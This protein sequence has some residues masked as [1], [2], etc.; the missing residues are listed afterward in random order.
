[1]VFR[2][3]SALLLVMSLLVVA[4]VAFT[5]PP[6]STRI[7]VQTA[8]GL[9]VVGALVALIDT[10]GKV[11]VE[12]LSNEDGARSLSVPA[13]TYRVQVRRIG[14]QPFIS[15]PLVL[16]R[17]E[18]VLLVITDQP[19]VLSTVTV[20]PGSRCRS[21]EQD[22][23]A[24]T[25]VWGEIAKA[26]RASQLTSEDVWG[27][28]LVR[29][30]TRETSRGGTIIRSD[31]TLRRAIGARPFGAVD[32]RIL[33]TTGYVHGNSTQGWEFFGPDE[34]VLLSDQ[35]AV[36]HCFKVVRDRKRFGQVG[37]SFEPVLG[38]KQ[39]DIAGVIWVSE[40]TAELQEMTFRYVNAGV[41][42]G[43]DAGGRTHFLKMPSGAWI[44]DEWSLRFPKLEGRPTG[45][46]FV[47]VGHFE[48]GGGIVRESL[49]VRRRI[50]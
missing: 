18:G 21:F 31:S 44:V 23:T 5:Q 42:S 24:L 1:M 48:T 35:F 30:Y 20:S 36:T 46:T 16:P 25:T 6:A 47:E 19:I 9:A 2:S 43:F 50:P 29:T 37:V 7:R 28:A 33:A 26:L 8:E 14:F 40:K 49:S 34:M 32:P 39:S 15:E 17:R 22:V 38:R 10:A 4:S 12:G 41:I 13:G 45:N 27:I 3:R 11:S